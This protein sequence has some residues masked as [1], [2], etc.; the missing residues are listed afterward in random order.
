MLAWNEELS[1]K[2]KQIDEQLR[3]IL[4]FLAQS[5]DITRMPNNEEKMQ[6]LRGLLVDMVRYVRMHFK[7]E[8]R[9]ME[10]MKFP[11][12]AKHAASHKQILNTLVKS[13]ANQSGD[14]G[15]FAL[16]IYKT[17]KTSFI[18]HICLEDKL[19]STY[20]K[21]VF[22]LG[23]ITY[24]LEFCNE[25]FAQF[26]DITKQEQHKYICNCYGV[27]HMI[28][29]SMHKMLVSDGLFLRCKQCKKPLIPRD[30]QLDDDKLF[31]QVSE[32]YSKLAASVGVDL[33]ALSQSKVEQ[34]DVK[35]DLSGDFCEISDRPKDQRIAKSSPNRLKE[36]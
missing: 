32:E 10:V 5:E 4:L 8:E 18:T 14:V 7:D 30:K 26:V 9:L 15:D 16:G 3:R 28:C 13:I 11:H 1:I 23:E 35:F 27:S 31:K 2:N 25:I 36:Q 19:L 34:V 24:S 17:L 22:E 29:D 12:A 33:A 6:A 21:V 20:N